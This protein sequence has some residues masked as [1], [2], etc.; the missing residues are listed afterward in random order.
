M[1]RTG[2][3][4]SPSVRNVRVDP[5]ALAAAPSPRPDRQWS[6]GGA[7]HRPR[8]CR[9]RFSSCLAFLRRHYPEQVQGSR[10]PV[11]TAPLSLSVGSPSSLDTNLVKA[12]QVSVARAR[13]QRAL[14]ESPA[15]TP[16]EGA[17]R[18]GPS[19]GRLGFAEPAPAM[20]SEGGPVGAVRGPPRRRWRPSA[21]RP[22]SVHVVFGR[23][24]PPH[25]R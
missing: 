15:T 7:G 20:R 21:A 14:A 17:T 10:L 18:P 11:R 19:T 25:P 3:L 6:A 8:S 13:M 12:K 24:A 4:M 1:R 23:G 9:F 2:T 16:P 5:G 22:R